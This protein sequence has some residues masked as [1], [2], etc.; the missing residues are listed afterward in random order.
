[1]ATAPPSRAPLPCATSTAIATVPVG[2]RRRGGPRERE[3]RA[4]ARTWE[5]YILSTKGFNVL[6]L[7]YCGCRVLAC[8][9]ANNTGMVHVGLRM[10]VANVLICDYVLN[11]SSLIVAGRRLGAGPLPCSTPARAGA[12][13]QKRARATAAARGAAAAAEDAQPLR[14]IPLTSTY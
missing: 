1:M 13:A 10:H 9:C 8:L 6:A 12:Q 11:K 2:E 4:R 5:K 7:L 14:V 3:G